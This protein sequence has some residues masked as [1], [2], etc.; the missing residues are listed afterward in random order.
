MREDPAPL[1]L[2][3]PEM[4]SQTCP[5][6]CVLVDF[7]FGQVDNH[8]SVLDSAGCSLLALANTSISLFL[9]G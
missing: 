2:S 8:P 7:R 5:E 6:A 4:P 3:G 9:L 1:S